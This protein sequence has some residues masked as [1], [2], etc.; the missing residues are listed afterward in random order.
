MINIAVLITCYNRKQNTI[1][2]LKALFKQ[3]NLENI[4]LKVFLVDDASSDGSEE[5]IKELFPAAIIIKG[6]GNLF[7]AR[8]MALAWETALKSEEKFDH[9][10][11]LNDDTY[12]LDTAINE[13]LKTKKN[14]NEIIVGST[15]DPVTKNRT[16]GGTKFTNKFFTPFKYKMVDVNGEI[17]EIDT[18]NG[19]IVMIPHKVYCKIGKIDGKFEHAFADIEYSMRAKKNNINILLAAKYVGECSRKTLNHQNYDKL[20]IL[21]KI[22]KLF[23]RKEKPLKSWFRLSFKYGGIL[24]PVHFFIG[25]IKSILKILL[26]HKY[27]KKN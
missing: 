6:S 13:L 17:Q 10:M 14:G 16:Y 18:M 25:Y 1:R 27:F 4:N 26:E 8:G 15:F 7:W 24:W 2:C 3:K 20:S 9:Y 21:K 5:A 19:N 12:L 11:W 22:S 23:D